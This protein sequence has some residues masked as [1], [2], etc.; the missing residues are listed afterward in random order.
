MSSYDPILWGITQITPPF[1]A[2]TLDKFGG[3]VLCAETVAF[4]VCLGLAKRIGAPEMGFRMVEALGRK[5][6][7]S[8]TTR[9]ETKENTRNAL[10]ESVKTFDERV[11]AEKAAREQALQNFDQEQEQIRAKRL[12]HE[13]NLAQ[14]AER[15]R[16]EM[17][18]R[19]LILTANPAAG[20]AQERIT[21]AQKLEK[22]ENNHQQEKALRA[23]AIAREDAQAVIDRERLVKAIDDPERDAQETQQREHLV[24]SVKSYGT[25]SRLGSAFH[26]TS[27][28]MGKKLAV[29][30]LIG[31]TAM[32]G[33]IWGVE[34]LAIGS[35]IGLSGSFNESAKRVGETYK[36]A[37]N[38]A[39]YLGEKA[40]CVTGLTPA[41]KNMLNMRTLPNGC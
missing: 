5:T 19:L 6:G 20:S 18:Q 38:G 27:W 15:Q 33:T 26:Q 21:L 12:L 24:D 40:A 37:G 8:P 23:D 16:N 30:T 29:Y 2:E 31:W 28:E 11:G 34:D 22:F 9:M 35:R 4:L 39:V 1:V 32:A 25:P 41:V 10:L 13:E 7:L 36:W 14:N 3:F 17:M